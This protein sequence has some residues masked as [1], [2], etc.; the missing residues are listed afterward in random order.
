MPNLMTLQTKSIR[1]APDKHADVTVTV[2]SIPTV[3]GK[4]QSNLLIKGHMLPRQP[5]LPQLSQL[6]PQRFELFQQLLL[7]V[8]FSCH[9]MED[10]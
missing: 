10:V 2:P 4:Q 1:V 8:S 3:P 7:R 9:H 6:R 5:A